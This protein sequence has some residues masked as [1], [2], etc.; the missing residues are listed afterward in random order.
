MK[1]QIINHPLFGR[2]RFQH[3]RAINMPNSTTVA[4]LCKG[5]ASRVRM[6]LSVFFLS[7][8]DPEAAVQVGPALLTTVGGLVTLGVQHPFAV[9]RYEEYGTAI[10]ETQQYVHNL[11]GMGLTFTEILWYPEGVA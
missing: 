7:T 9:L 3:Q 10:Q 1:G 6:I 4:E 5:N 11:A 8:L 2:G